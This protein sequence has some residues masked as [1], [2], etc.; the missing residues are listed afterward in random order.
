MSK[1]SEQNRTEQNRLPLYKSLFWHC[2]SFFK[3]I[4]FIF[5]DNFVGFI[6]FSKFSWSNPCLFI[7]NNLLQGGSIMT[8]KN[9]LKILVIMIAVLSLFAVSCRKAS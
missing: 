2:K 5:A 7:K 9:I 8:Q 6:R 4:I 3:K 1:F